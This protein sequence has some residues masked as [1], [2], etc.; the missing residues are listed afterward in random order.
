MNLD[1]SIGSCWFIYFHRKNIE[2]RPNGNLKSE[3]GGGGGGKKRQVKIMAHERITA[4]EIFIVITP[5]TL[6]ATGYPQ[7]SVGW[8]PPFYL[9]RFAIAASSLLFNACQWLHQKDNNNNKNKK[10]IDLLLLFLFEFEFEL[11][12]RKE[13]G[14]GGLNLN[15]F[16]GGRSWRRVTAATTAH[17]PACHGTHTFVGRVFMYWRLRRRQSA[18]SALTTPIFTCNATPFFSFSFKFASVTAKSE[19]RRAVAGAVWRPHLLLLLIYTWIAKMGYSFGCGC[20]IL[21]PTPPEEF[22]FN[23]HPAANRTERQGGC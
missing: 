14:M 2:F 9:F 15:V 11:D 23:L 6:S 13:N 19:R 1:F 10:E 16:I 4:R 20:V 12:E 21:I 17:P 18:R 7:R 22:E 8:S 3:E 5:S